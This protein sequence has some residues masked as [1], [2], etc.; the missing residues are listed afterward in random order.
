M[1]RVGGCGPLA[2]M[3][4]ICPPHHTLIICIDAYRR[5]VTLNGEAR[6]VVKMYVRA[7]GRNF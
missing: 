4:F 1:V 2:V 5:Q 3:G 7:V 6:G